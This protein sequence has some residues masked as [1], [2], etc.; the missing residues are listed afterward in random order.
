MPI[1]FFLLISCA[2][3]ISKETR[4]KVDL[5]LTPED[6][7]KNPDAYKG[8]AV[9]LGGIIVSLKNT[10]EGTYIEVLQNPLDYRGRPR[11]IDRSQG[12]FIIF[13]KGYLDTAIYSS[14][15]RITVAG[16]I[17]GK[18][19]R[20]LGEIQYTYPLIKSIEIRLSERN[21]DIP[22]RF[23]IGVFKGF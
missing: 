8:R 23:S 6:V 22:I 10:D 5:N 7:F 17:S 20:P 14:G 2:H 16:V 11:D 12:R 13:H 9:I 15:K 1:L 18:T 4:Q 3:V 19:I 21:Y